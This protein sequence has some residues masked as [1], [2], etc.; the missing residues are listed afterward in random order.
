[1]QITARMM[2]KRMGVAET[3]I[4]FLNFGIMHSQQRRK[5]E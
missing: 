2:I 1:M 4:I 5:L 3:K